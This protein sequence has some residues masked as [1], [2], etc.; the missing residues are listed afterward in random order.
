MLYRYYFTV[1]FT[2]QHGQYSW[3]HLL[4]VQA[5][6]IYFLSWQELQDEQPGWRQMGA[7]PTSAAATDD[8][9]DVDLDSHEAPSQPVCP[10]VFVHLVANP[11]QWGV[12]VGLTK[13]SR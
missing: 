10:Y 9:T 4:F 13:P 1:A 5:V 12:A 7:S 2:R 8:A 6:G 3:Q 11:A